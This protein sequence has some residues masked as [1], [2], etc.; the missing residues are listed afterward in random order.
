MSK[1]DEPD[2]SNLLDFSE[3]IPTHIPLPAPVT[4]AQKAELRALGYDE[5]VIRLMQADDVHEVLETKVVGV[6]EPSI[7]SQDD[8]D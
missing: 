2:Y 5:E 8:G 7:G 3:L 1:S 6:N 4:E